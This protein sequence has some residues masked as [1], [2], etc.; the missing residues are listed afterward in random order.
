[1]R[2]RLSQGR[3]A[4]ARNAHERLDIPVIAESKTERD[5]ESWPRFILDW[6][7]GMPHLIDIDARI[8]RHE[9]LAEGG[10]L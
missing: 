2:V 4:R 5:P 7:G 1:M 8:E 3:M 6:N 10:D 9:M